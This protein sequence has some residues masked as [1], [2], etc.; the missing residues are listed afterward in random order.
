[1]KIAKKAFTV[2]EVLISITIFL[3][4]TGLILANYKK[5]ENNNTFRLQ[6]FDIEDSIRLVQNMSLTGQKIN[7]EIP[8]NAYGISFDMA[9][10]TYKIFGDRG[11]DNCKGFFNDYRC[12]APNEIDLR[13]QEY[14]INKNLYFSSFCGKTGDNKRLDIFFSSPRGNINTIVYDKGDESSRL[15][16]GECRILLKSNRADGSWSIVISTST[17]RIYSI[18]SN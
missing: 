6:S 11:D 13:G 15:N 1:M 18:F 9:S 12:S 17:N 7:G 8:G 16:F 2:L 4:I 14:A 3:V 10:G 5:S